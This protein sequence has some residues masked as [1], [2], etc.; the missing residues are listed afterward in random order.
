M[1]EEKSPP[2]EEDL[3]DGEAYF[4]T[5]DQLTEPESPIHHQSAVK[6]RGS[7]GAAMKGTEPIQEQRIERFFRRVYAPA[8]YRCRHAVVATALALAAA[9]IFLVA[10]RMQLADKVPNLLPLTH[11][12]QRVE[13]LLRSAFHS[14]VWSEVNLLFGVRDIDRT[15]VDPNDFTKL[16]VP[17]WDQ[18]FDLD[19]PESQLHILA[20]CEAVQLRAADLRLTSEAGSQRCLMQRFKEWQEKGGQPFPVPPGNFSRTFTE[21]RLE[22]TEGGHRWDSSMDLVAMDDTG[23]IVTFIAR[24]YVDM[25]P[26]DASTGDIRRL[27]QQW[28][29]IVS[30]ANAMP[31]AGHARAVQASDLWLRLGIERSIVHSAQRAP[32]VSLAAAMVAVAATTSSLTAAAAAAAT[33]TLVV[34]TMLTWLILAGWQFGVIESLCVSILIG[35]SIDYCIHVAITFVESKRATALERLQDCLGRSGGT[36]TGAALTTIVS[37]SMLFFCQITV[38]NQVALVMVVNTAAGYILSLTFF[39]AAMCVCTGDR[40]QEAQQPTD[41]DDTSCLDVELTAKGGDE[42]ALNPTETSSSVPGSQVE[43]AV[44]PVRTTATLH[45]DSPRMHLFNDR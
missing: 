3:V 35:T 14:E 24:Y 30:H 29:G 8:L 10:T 18:S 4:E 15:G 9:S 44:Q 19:R 20:M 40:G 36:V 21:W 45:T 42:P 13:F 26:L 39:G 12:L 1:T 22:T 37:S 31:G 32:A 16:G 34:L 27:L 38:F 23:K 33:I 25:N 5:T 2:E 43:P 28:D 6:P 7:A 41:V 11:P 17:V